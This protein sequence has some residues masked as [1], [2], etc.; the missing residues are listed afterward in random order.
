MTLA[1]QLVILAVAMSTFSVVPLLWEAARRHS[2]PLFLVGTGAMISICCFDLVPDVLKAGGVIAGWE[3]LGTWLAYSGI[4]WLPF[5]HHDHDPETAEAHCH[6]ADPRRFAYFMGPL[7][8]HGIASGMLL[9]VS[10]ELGARVAG[11]VFV[12]LFAHKI[13][14][15]LLLASILVGVRRS[16]RW[17][18]AMAAA[19]VLALPLGAWLAWTLGETVL[20][21]MA[22]HISGVAVGT[23]LGCLVFDFLMPSFK[24]LR[25]RAIGYLWMAGGFFLTQWVLSSH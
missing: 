4:H 16:I 17:K 21:D 2:R 22:V 1:L 19:Y 15:S 14:E 13:Y 6:Y 20:N 7:I 9:G 25:G 5:F 10:R 24:Q 12:A 23:L 3:I 11:E 18:I 8:A